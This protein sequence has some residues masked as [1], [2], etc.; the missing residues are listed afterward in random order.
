M[1][2]DLPTL[3]AEI[4]RLS[5][6]AYPECTHEIRDK[7]ACAQFIAAITNG[8][9]KRTL[10]LEN[11]NSLKST[12]GKAMT[13]QTIQENN[14]L[15]RRNHFYQNNGFSNNLEQRFNFDR[16][17][18]RNNEKLITGKKNKTFQENI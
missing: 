17:G 10:Q 14:F 15:K 13:I 2:E 6:L 4:K 8:F 9:L 12:I 18:L 5:R 3:G 16:N 1:E 7:I 11:I